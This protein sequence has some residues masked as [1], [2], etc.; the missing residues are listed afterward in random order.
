MKQQFSAAAAKTYNGFAVSRRRR[1]RLD[2][3]PAVAGVV[4]AAAVM[5]GVAGYSAAF[6]NRAPRTD[7][8]QPAPIVRA[9][10]A[11]L[12]S[13]DRE[14]VA[15]SAMILPAVRAE[16][17]SE[18]VDERSDAAKPSLRKHVRSAG[19]E[20]RRG[21]HAPHARKAAAPSRL[22]EAGCDPTQGAACGPDAQSLSHRL[23][24]AFDKAFPPDKHDP[25]LDPPY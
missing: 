21:S 7:D 22:A 15:V 14:G 11:P 17:V 2:G 24:Q 19:V 25:A 4:L 16:D 12:A 5:G 3:G 9:R 8:I 1:L 23:D 18:T 10:A 13:E 6:V 20:G